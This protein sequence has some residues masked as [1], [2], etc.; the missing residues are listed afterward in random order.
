MLAR[1]RLNFVLCLGFFGLLS[2]CTHPAERALEGRW[3]GQSVENFDQESIAA[4]SGWARGT[5][6]EFEGNRLKVTVPAEEPRP[7]SRA[8][9]VRTALVLKVAQQQAEL[10]K[11]LLKEHVR[12]VRL[13][14]VIQVY[15][16]Q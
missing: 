14:T 11:I 5:S 12:H 1:T 6:F 9:Q 10:G 2:G 7:F 3:D 16:D 13:D 8:R 15:G 4:A